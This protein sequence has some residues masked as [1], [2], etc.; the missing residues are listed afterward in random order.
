[1]IQYGLLSDMIENIEA[2]DQN[3]ALFF[4]LSQNDNKEYVIELNTNE[5][6][7]NEGIDATGISLESIGG[8]YS[9]FT[10]IIKQEDGLPTDRITLFQEGDFYDSF[11]VEVERDAFIIEADTIKGGEDLQN[12]WGDDIIGLTDESVS[13]LVRVIAPDFVDFIINEILQ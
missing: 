9:E 13:E 10:L 6:L 12:R 5:Q 3:K 7:F 2:L 8:P 11:R 4:V 1:M